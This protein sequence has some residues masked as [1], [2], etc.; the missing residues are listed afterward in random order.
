MK[1]KL[2]SFGL[3]L[4]ILLSL[5]VAL[6]FT[7]SAASSGMCGENLTWS[8]DDDG[9]LTIS[10]TGTMYDF[11]NYENRPPWDDLTIQSLVI[12]EGITHIGD[13]AFSHQQIFA[14]DIIIPEGVESLG[15]ASFAGLTKLKNVSLP[16][17][18]IVIGDFC[19][20]EGESL[21]NIHIPK[22]VSSLGE[23]PF[24]IYLSSVSCDE[25][26]QNFSAQDG[27]LF[28]KDKTEIL[29]YP[30]EKAGV[31]Y[32]ISSNINTIGEW[33]FFYNRNLQ[34]IIIPETVKEIQDCAF[35]CCENLTSI[36]LPNSI[37]IISSNLFS[38]CDNLYSVTIPKSV[39]SIEEMAFSGCYNLNKVIY[40]G[41]EEEWNKI[42]I[43]ENFNKYLINAK[44]HFN[45]ATEG[46]NQSIK[47]KKLKA[48]NLTV[49][50]NKKD[51]SSESDSYRLSSEA[52]IKNDTY[53]KTSNSKGYVQI[54]NNGSDIT[55]SKKGYISRT[56]SAKRANKSKKIYL[57]RDSGGK[58]IING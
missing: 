31:S 54:L 34:E 13:Y 52:E 28:N 40:T 6:P 21:E 33:A 45:A 44:K 24:G 42:T 41:S 26:N 49:Y 50:E 38:Y 29:C 17:S 37:S 5:I 51:S 32:M 23:N 56:I 20:G 4:T 16:D 22:N 14:T 53:T 12:N 48:L 30:P 15:E 47:N 58:P 2:S 36:E 1:K 55:V 57:Q 11:D 10:G 18:L 3:A 39:K 25:E 7:V 35:W 27:I 8:V 43:S 19:F 46:I 9:T